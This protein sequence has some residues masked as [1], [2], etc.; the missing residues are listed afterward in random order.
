MAKSKVMFTI[1]FVVVTEDRDLVLHDLGTVEVLDAAHDDAVGVRRLDLLEQ[2][3][4]AGL[5]R[6][7]G[8]TGLAEGETAT[9]SRFA[10]W[11]PNPGCGGA[12]G[13]PFLGIQSDSPFLGFEV[14]LTMLA[15]S[16]RAFR[17]ITI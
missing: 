15:A 12:G 16:G 6:A 4:V 7:Q 13:S 14:G 17:R 3:L 11:L 2:G 5:L 8:K 10:E 9:V 1:E